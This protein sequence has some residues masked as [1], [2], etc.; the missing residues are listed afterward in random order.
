MIRDR[1]TG[2]FESLFRDLNTEEEQQFRSW[3]RDN[4][5]P[6]MEINNFWHPVIRDEIRVMQRES[7]S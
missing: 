7:R 2:R 3:A 6:G 4:W 5:T 1:K